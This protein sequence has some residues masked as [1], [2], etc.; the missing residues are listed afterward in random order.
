LPLVDGLDV[1]AA[2]QPIFDLRDGSV[3]GYEALARPRDGTSPEQLFA[4][5]REQGRLA[6]VDRACRQAALREAS[7]AG[8]RAPFALFLNA[9]AGA[10]E[11]EVPE[12]PPGHATLVMEITESALTERPDAVLRSLT[13]LRTH[14][15]G[16]SLDDIGADSR[17]LALM[18]LLYPDVIKID[19][20]LLSER[21]PADIARVVT[22]VGFEAER[23]HATV[24]AE[25][26]D[27]E[28]QLATARAAGAT[29]GQGF[30]L[31]EPGPLPDPLPEPGRPLRL[32]GAGG[33]PDG[34][35]PYQRVTNWRHPTHGTPELAERAAALL[36][37]QGAA[38]GDT[39]MLLVAPPSGAGAAAHA[40]YEMLREQIG[41]IGVLDDGVLDGTWTEVALGPGYG[42]CFVAQR[43]GDEWRF[44]TSYDRELVVE[45]ALL[46]MA[47]L[48]PAPPRR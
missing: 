25:G 48:P 38:L 43:D 32:A 26:I 29:L 19:L 8:L 23:R 14:G 11:H 13:A 40:R 44:S 2:F 24:L 36:S 28:A 27:S 12:L 5:A 47:R 6:E 18:P 42:A 21:E 30:L 45:C 41:F 1:Q 31:G 35:L 34:P 46:L 9:D 22:A 16:V 7:E 33:A 15:W 37:S 39:G 3:I 17:S 10:L 4:A 20:R